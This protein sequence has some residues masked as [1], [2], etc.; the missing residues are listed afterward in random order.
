MFN[1]EEY[2]AQSGTE[3]VPLLLSNMSQQLILAAML[4]LQSRSNWLE[5]EAAVWDEIEAAVAEAYEEIIEEQ[6]LAVEN[7]AFTVTRT[8]S[9]GSL[10]ANAWTQIPISSIEDP[11]DLATLSSNQIT[12]K[13]SGLYQ[14]D[15]TLSARNAATAVSKKS[16]VL[17]RVSPDT[18]LCL[19]TSIQLAAS[20]IER[21]WSAIVDIFTIE[22]N[23]VVEFLIYGDNSATTIE[24]D[25][26]VGARDT[27]CLNARFTKLHG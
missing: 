27:Y 6:V 20:G 25:G 2:S 3:D 14:V 26:A 10:A 23:Q 18:T 19:S 13:E 7:K 15:L 4:Q 21:A 24:S 11:G 16:V 9:S 22:A 5:V 17:H 12:V 8:T 1:W